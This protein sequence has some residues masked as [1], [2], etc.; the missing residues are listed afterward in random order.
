MGGTTEAP[1]DGCSDTNAA[2]S[3]E[4]PGRYLSASSPEP[5]ALPRRKLV[6]GG[7]PRPS[8][9]T[10][11]ALVPGELLLLLARIMSSQR[12]A[13]TAPDEAR[14]KRNEAP[15]GCTLLGQRPPPRH[16]PNTAEEE[17]AHTTGILSGALY[18]QRRVSQAFLVS[19]IA[20]ALWAP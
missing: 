11:A 6:G 9:E 20:Q 15:A 1:L 10:G 12:Q 14:A 19:T 13:L 8:S 18:G 5:R 3:F 7:G 17:L 2:C 4:P 16:P